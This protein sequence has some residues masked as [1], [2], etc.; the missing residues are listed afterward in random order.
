MTRHFSPPAGADDTSAL[1]IEVARCWR[2][3]R[4]LGRP[5]QPSLFAMLSRTGRGMLAPV[6]D[7]L[8]TPAETMFGRP[9]ATGDG[10][11]VSEDEHQLIGLLLGKE[12]RSRGTGPVAA[13]DCAIEST[14]IMLRI[15]GTPMSATAA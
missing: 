5:V 1:L 13:L 7:S 6:F 9:L 12:V 4:D 14:H 11:D 15:T 3:A 8:M 2:E 10:P